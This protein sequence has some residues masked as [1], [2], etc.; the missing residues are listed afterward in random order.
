MAQ[1]QG[2]TRSGVRVV[3]AMELSLTAN[4][5]I[6]DVKRMVWK[7]GQGVANP[8]TLSFVSLGLVL[9]TV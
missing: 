6:G 2:E 8:S 7:Y 5:L 1:T 4:Q 3:R 9:L